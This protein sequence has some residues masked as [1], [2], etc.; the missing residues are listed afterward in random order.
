MTDAEIQERGRQ[1]GL[2]DGGTGRAAA[3][4]PVVTGSSHN[5]LGIICKTQPKA[6][7]VAD[8]IR[9]AGHA[10]HLLTAE[11]TSFTSGVTVC[12]A[13]LAKGLE[14]DEVIVPDAGDKTYRTAMDR[15]LLYVA[16]TRAMHNLTLTLRATVAPGSR[17]DPA[18]LGFERPPCAISAALHRL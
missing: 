18:G 2:D 12:C 7:R 8:A 13:H 15:N 5:T 3:R 14:F 6:E 1:L 9:D 4:G 17:I 11:S 10:V 16:C